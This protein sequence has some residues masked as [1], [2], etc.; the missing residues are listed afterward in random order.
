[1]GERIVV[2]NRGRIQQVAPPLEIYERPANTF[3]ASFIGTPPMNLFP[4]GTLSPL[5]TVGLRPEHIRL[6]AD[7]GADAPSAATVDFTEPLGSETLVHLKFGPTAFS[8]TV[9]VAGFAAC[10]AG[11][12]VALL[13]DMAHAVEFLGPSGERFVPEGGKGEVS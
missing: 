1:M 4:I 8:V 2:M 9:R 5:R 12:R 11:E 3:V 13:P 7:P 10:R 6:G